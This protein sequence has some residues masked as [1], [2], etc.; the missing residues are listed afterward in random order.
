[1]VLELIE[2]K[3]DKIAKLGITAR[4]EV[5]LEDPSFFG[6]KNHGANTSTKVKI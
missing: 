1:M 4:F 6:I 3:F 2:V 5:S